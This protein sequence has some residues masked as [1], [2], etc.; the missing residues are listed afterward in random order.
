M[1]RLAR[2][3]S[4]RRTPPPRLPAFSLRAGLGSPLPLHPVPTSAP[5]PPLFSLLPR[6]DGA[7]DGIRTRDPHLGN[8]NLPEVRALNVTPLGA[9]RL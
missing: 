9:W 7:D 4:R 6:T 2:F 8:V 5:L 3:A 1:W